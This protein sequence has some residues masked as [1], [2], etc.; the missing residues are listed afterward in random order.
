MVDHEDVFHD[1]R[2]SVLSHVS[3]E[4][5]TRLFFHLL[6]PS[7]VSSPSSQVTQQTDLPI[8]EDLKVASILSASTL[9][10]ATLSSLYSDSK[11]MF[12]MLLCS[13]RR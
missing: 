6:P 3:N 8:V 1:R 11:D 10:A 2:S 12:V 7:T 5:N 13:F 9:V 4:G